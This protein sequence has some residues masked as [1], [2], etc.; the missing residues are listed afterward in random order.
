MYKLTHL[1]L[2]YYLFPYI[3]LL[4]ISETFLQRSVDFIDNWLVKQKVNFN[5]NLQC[6]FPNLNNLHNNKTSKSGFPVILL[7]IASFLYLGWK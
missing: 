4:R 7:L 6:K 5:Y 2:G 3:F 1:K